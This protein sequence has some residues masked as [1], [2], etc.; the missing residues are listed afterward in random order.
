MA[1]RAGTSHAT[2]AAYEQ[3]RVVP[4]VDTLARVVSAAGFALE[5]S[6]ARR[7]RNGLAGGTKGD[8]LVAVL[9]LAEQFPARHDAE[10]AYP[11]LARP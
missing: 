8:E 1:S 11:V 4:G 2:L 9:E 3:G 7:C 5:V 6:L 10:L